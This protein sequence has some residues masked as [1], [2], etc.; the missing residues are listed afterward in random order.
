MILGD[1]ERLGLIRFEVE[2]KKDRKRYHKLFLVYITLYDFILGLCLKSPNYSIY[3]YMCFYSIILTRSWI[4]IKT[5]AW[6]C[7]YVD[8]PTLCQPMV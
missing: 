8:S 3:F 1:L 2:V 6:D 5:F 7:W 4:I